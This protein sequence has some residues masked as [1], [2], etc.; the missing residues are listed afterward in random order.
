M[1]FYSYGFSIGPILIRYYSLCFLAGV[2]AGAWP[3]GRNGK[4]RGIAPDTA[5]DSL[6]W[7]LIGGILGARLWHVLLPSKSS[8]ITLQYYLQ[9]PS[10]ILAV[11]NGG[12]G[13]PGGVI[14]GLFGGWLYCKKNGFKL[15]RFADSIAPGL[16]L[17]QAIGRLGNYFNQELYGAP[18]DLPWA[19]TI[20]PDNRVR[21]F[22]NQAT[23]HPLFL[24]EMI[25]NLINM[26]LLLWIDRKFE[27]KLKDGDIFLC[28]LVI[29]PVGRFL[30][31]FLRLDTA[32]VGGLNMN[33][34]IMAVTALAAASAL[35][36]RHSLKRKAV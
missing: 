26:A 17:G 5:W 21:G 2:L 24:Y 6:F 36:I 23:Y 12:L 1:E 22:E 16:A 19:L 29:Y 7:I 11:W 30:L 28:Y 34:L 31:E 14:G 3:F 33:Q 13:I 35:V 18:T 20:D 9:N 32:M 27:K 10:Q 8:G 25:Y 4:R 15:A